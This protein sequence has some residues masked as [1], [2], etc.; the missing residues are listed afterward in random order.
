[1]AGKFHHE[2]IY[3]GDD[4]LATLARARIAICGA[5]ALGSNLADA[6]VRQGAARLRVIDFDRVEEHNIGT[7][8]YSQSDIGQPKADAL[9]KQ[10]FRAA[11]M[12][13]EAVRKE[14]TADNVGVLLK[15]VD[16]VVDC[17]DNTASRQLV[18]LHAR[19]A[20]TPTLHAGLFADYGEVIWD[21]TYRVPGD[22]SAGNDC[23]YPLAR[24][25]IVLTATVAAET[26]LRFV[27]EAHRDSWS[28]TLGDLQIRAIR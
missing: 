25:L 21:D 20:G 3:R 9:R 22:A 2:A 17:F 28:I 26:I 8:T 18:Q 12:E 27:T 19:R 23:D 24:N 7:Q 6:L 4:A 1:M 13:I 5:G 10:L 15:D 14:L 16:L 11:G